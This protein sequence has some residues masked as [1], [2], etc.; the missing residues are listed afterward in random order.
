MD[1]SCYH[2]I[3][4]CINF[5]AFSSGPSL[6]SRAT[7]RRLVVLLAAVCVLVVHLACLSMMNIWPVGVRVKD[8]ACLGALLIDCAVFFSREIFVG[9]FPKIVENEDRFL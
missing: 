7:K 8:R 2:Q 5:R 3:G 9:L 1:S 6:I 4:L